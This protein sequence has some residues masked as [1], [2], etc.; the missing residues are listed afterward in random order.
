MYEAADGWLPTLEGE[1]ETP[2]GVADAV[3]VDPT[4][5]VKVV[6]VLRAGLVL[7]EQVGERGKVGKDKGCVCVCRFFINSSIQPSRP[8]PSSPPPKPTTSATSATKKRCKRPRI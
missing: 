2:C 3:F 7:L 8:P 4:Q 1:V 6:P 5:P